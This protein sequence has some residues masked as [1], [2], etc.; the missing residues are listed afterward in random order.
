MAALESCVNLS[1]SET[2]ALCCSGFS[3]QRGPERKGQRDWLGL[4]EQCSAASGRQRRRKDL[5]YLE[6]PP[7]ADQ[8]CDMGASHLG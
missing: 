5:R 1:C 3:A 7:A 4:Q 6:D 2:T 8:A